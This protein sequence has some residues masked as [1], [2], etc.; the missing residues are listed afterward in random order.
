MH[1]GIRSFTRRSLGVGGFIRRNLFTRRSRVIIGGIVGLLFLT[2]PLFAQSALKWSFSVKDAGNC[3]VD[4]IITGTIQDGFYTY[5][6]FLESDDGPVAT[7]LTFQEGAHYKLVGKAKESGGV[8]KVHDQVFDMTLS[9]FKHKAIFTQR[10]EVKDPSKPIAGYLNFMACNDDHCEPPKDVDFSFNIPALN[11]CGGSTNSTSKEEAAGSQTSNVPKTLVAPT[12]PDSST[13]SAKQDNAPE[14]S[15]FKGFFYSKREI[16]SAQFV[17][18]CG[19]TSSQG[20]SDDASWVTLFLLC[21]IGGLIALLTPCVFPM[22]PMTVSFFVKRSKDRRAGLRNAFIYAGSIVLIFVVLGSALTS[23]LGP[24]VLNN[25][26]T[27]MWFNLLMFVLLVVFAFSFFGFYEIQ[28]PSSWVNKSD[29]MADRGGLLGTFFMA[30]TLVL[31]SFS[32]TGPIVGTL[33]VE[34]ARSNAGASLLGFIPLKPAVGMFG[35]GLGLAL[36]FGLFAMFPGWLN[37]LP[38]SGGWMDNVKVTLGILELA[39]AFKFLS[40]ADMVEQW[41]ILK[42]EPFMIIWILCALLLGL[43]Q[44]SILKWKGNESKPG[45]GRLTLAFASLAFAAY[46]GWGL[47]GY[48]SLSLLSGLAPP[49]H[50]SFKKVSETKAHD[51]PGCPH[52]LDCYHDFDEAMAVAKLENKPIFV[53]FT[54][55]GCV[56][57]R[58]MEETVWP[59]NGIIDR[60]RNDYIVVSLYVDEKVR[61]FPD[62]D[63]AYLLD[64]KTGEK[65]RTVGSK[66]ASFQVNNFDV[67]AQPYYVLMH[68]DG[69]T[70]LNKP[71]DYA[72]GNDPKAYKAFLDCGLEAFERLNKDGA[73]E[74]L[75]V[76]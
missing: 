30:F 21:F 37:S 67:S 72:N 56:N 42:F 33:L 50:Y 25:M 71:T 4:L 9:K 35:F 58:K 62:N 2:I 65:L 49:V 61:L 18:N 64:P 74:R 19:D 26:S 52:G 63:F 10:V 48:K 46:V 1:T 53:D 38:K 59:L 39:L 8:I 47:V 23:M 24:S 16:N 3:Q 54:G 75:G 70:L 20:S 55:H 57:C 34:A 6:Q 76:K 5:S 36:P 28:L 27:N 73:G 43:Y 44:L 31:V 41:G 11:G 32:C 66:W 17:G 15:N 14:D 45:M 7:T 29:K 22:I 69:K 60:L 12:P 40:T 68:H 51:G 13:T